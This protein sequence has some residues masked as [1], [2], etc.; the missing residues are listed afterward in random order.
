MGEEMNEKIGFFRKIKYSVMPNKYNDLLGIK[1]SKTIGF[2]VLFTMLTGVLSSIA[3]VML[4]TSVIREEFNGQSVEEYILE[5]LPEFSVKNGELQIEEPSTIEFGTGYIVF[6]N[7]IEEINEVELERIFGDREV[8]EAVIFGKHA[9]GR[10]NSFVGFNVTPYGDY[11]ELGL[12]NEVLATYIKVGMII[13]VIAIVIIY[14]VFA[15]ISYLFSGFIYAGFMYVISLIASKKVSYARIF[16]MCLYAKVLITLV[17]VIGKPLMSVLGLGF[18]G[19]LIALVVNFTIMTIALMRITE[20]QYIMK[21][22]VPEQKDYTNYQ[23]QSQVSPYEAY[24]IDPT[25]RLEEAIERTSIE[26]KLIKGIFFSK[27]DVEEIHY[28]IQNSREAEAILKIRYIS[29]FSDKEAKELIDHW[30][31]YTK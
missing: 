19:L 23:Q 3:F 26:G 8:S 20:D 24:R 13:A 17:G 10:Y 9:Y 2:I 31:E 7:S 21:K 18:F 11:G 30:H 14:I 16:A 25:Q 29:G 15:P 28:L 5:S 4:M 6:D 27:T 12:N 1:L 22:S